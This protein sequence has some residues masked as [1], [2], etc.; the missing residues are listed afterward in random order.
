MCGYR[1]FVFVS[2]LVGV[3]LLM[4]AGPVDAG[5]LESR[6]NEAFRGVYRRSPTAIENA[7]WLGR[8]VRGEKKTFEAL[9][10]AM[11]YGLA[12]GKTMSS[13]QAQGIKTTAGSDN[14]NVLIKD[15]LPLFVQIYGNDPTS[16]EKAWWR[17]RISCNEITTR[18]ALTNSMQYHKSKKARQGSSAICGGTSVAVSLVGGIV[19]KAIAGI[20][21]HP[22][23]DQVRIAIYKTDGRA[24]HVTAD[25]KYQIREGDS[26]ILGT[27]GKDDVA[28]VS[29]SGGSYHVRGSGVSFDTKEKIRLVPLNQAIM[30][31]KSYSD[32][33]A[34]YPGK[35]YN[36]FRGV[37]EIRKDD[38][39][40]YLWAINE[41]RAEY[42]LRG[43]AET[44]GNG[45]AEYLKALA[46]AARTYVLYHKV[47]TGGRSV[48]GGWDINNT[49][50]DQLYRGYEYELITPRMASEFAKTKGVIVTDSEA[51]SPVSTVY[52]SDSDGRTRSA[53]EKWNTDRFP[54]L[55]QSVKDPHHVASACKGHC[56]GMSA[57]GAYGFANEDGWSWQKILKY[58]YKGVKLVKAY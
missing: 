24:I 37:I 33:S 51:D 30:Q 39:K 20:S 2:V 15:T 49:A 27:L 44:S 7:Y 35:N 43:L 26:K 54:H 4:M 36:R 48:S 18:Q 19:R 47:V 45:P 29:W 21:S 1:Y 17:K 23:G 8:V 41:L 40:N 5:T 46:T 28:Q 31:I 56:V 52:F 32:P 9:R 55:Q 10:G 14:K 12:Q 6:V 38:A 13:A 58:Y 25:G 16:A 34:T 42:Y 11:F 57:Q 53:K 3:G 50:E 22:M